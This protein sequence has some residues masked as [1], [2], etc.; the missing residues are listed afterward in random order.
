MKE[1]EYMNIMSGIREE[2][3]EEAVSWD[4]SERKRI[5]QIRRMTT[6]FGAV[7]AAIAVVVGTIA[8][9]ERK[10]DL[11]AADSQESETESVTEDKTLNLFGGHG[12]IEV[13]KSLWCDNFYRDDDYWYDGGLLEKDWNFKRRIL[14]S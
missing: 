7:A 10:D 8:D 13:I 1:N 3:I 6:G 11:L 5:R 4:G 12:D 2:F 9:K 14:K